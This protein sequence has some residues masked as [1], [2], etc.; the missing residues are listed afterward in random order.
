MRRLR[1]RS[2]R[3][4]VAVSTALLC[5]A[6][7]G[8]TA[9]AVDVGALWWDRSQLQNG[10]DSAALA[11]A[12]SCAKGSGVTTC[13]P[14]EMGMATTYATGN[15]AD[16][17]SSTVSVTSIT[18]GD[19]WVK[20]DVT[21]TRQHWFAPLIGHKSSVVTASATV[22]WGGIGGASV[23]PF[24]V[25]DCQL[26][27]IA[28]GS[29]VTLWTKGGSSPTC[30][31]TSGN[32]ITG[33]FGW[34][35]DP[36]PDSTD[37]TLAC[38]VKTSVNGTVTG[39]TGDP[40]PSLSNDACNSILSDL[41]GREVLLPVF[42]SYTGSGTNIV[43]HLSGY[44]VIRVDTYCLNANKGWGYPT[45]GCKSE[46]QKWITGTFIKKVFLGATLGGPSYGA[47]TV[48]LTA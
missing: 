37:P 18:H 4:A 20:V 12:Q 17:A 42:D 19:G 27:N 24:V 2:Q 44:A 46:N 45:S 6:L 31:L 36:N 29:T 39:N 7:V 22:S 26:A 10:A 38:T 35:K 41:H 40:G 8:F 21:T 28:S 48:Q 1:E 13:E 33:N 34:L 32:T 5:V 15:K 16:N 43:F 11:L 25:G 9:I 3:G 23:L 30:G 47:T 14:D